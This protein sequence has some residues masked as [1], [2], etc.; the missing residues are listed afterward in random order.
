MGQLEEWLKLAPPPP[1]L[2]SGQKWHVF[3]SYRSTERQWVLAL[4]DVL[5]QLKYQVFMDQFVLVAGEGLAS[6]LGEN[7][8]ASQSGILV[9]SARSADSAWCKKEYN[10][11]EGRHAN[12]DFS[13][14]AVRVQDVPMPP[15]VQ[16]ALWIDASD[17]RDGPRGTS[18]LRMLYGLQ[19]KPL[20]PE[21]VRLAASID[22]TTRKDLASIRSYAAGKDSEEIVRLAE[23]RKDDLAWQASPVLPCAAAQALISIGSPKAALAQLDGVRAAFPAAIRPR[24]L[25]GLALARSRN[26]KEAKA[27]LGELYELGERDPETVGIYARTWMDAYEVS[28][29]RLMLRRSRDLYAEGFAKTPSDYYPGINAAAKSIFLDEIEAGIQLAK[30]VEQL[31]GTEPKPGDYWRT[32]TVAEAQLIQR[33][34]DLAATRYEQAVAMAPG[35]IDDHRSTC[36]QAR[37]LLKHLS[38]TPE[39]VARVLGTFRREVDAEDAPSAIN[40]IRSQGCARVLTFT[41]FSGTGY[42]D[43]TEVRNLI[44]EELESFDPADTL[45]CAGA[46]REGI[47]MVYPIALQKGFR[48]AG[49]VS[50][51]ARS[52]GAKFSTECEVV[53]VVED[54]TWGGK[55]GNGRLSPTSQAMVGACDVMIGIGGGAIARDELDE[56]RKK[57]KSVRFHKADMN[58]KLAAEKAAKA[59]EE[60]PRDFAGEAQ[61]LFS[62]Q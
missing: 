39:Q 62:D 34:F 47:G 44:L 46:T 56:A 61:S 10:S 21:A 12:G 50:S 1:P 52:E 26:W 32:A 54:T 2:E 48:T 35:A 28:R 4:Y 37:L 57:G 29:D 31:V 8:N 51:R 59:G 22:D 30:A 40:G 17:Q 27:V 23:S 25:T 49:I 36:K 5:T 41:G 45:V 53:I 7:L 42:E 15:F 6:S 16:G 18:L 24:Q 58:H 20:P 3:L 60:P 33:N 43:E 38:A 13:F 14:V 55:Q 11:F 19:G 9:W